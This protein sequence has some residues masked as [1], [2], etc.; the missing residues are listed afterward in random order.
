[1]VYL[2]ALYVKMRHEG[3]VENRAVYVAIGI[4]LEGRKEVLGL[5]T[6]GNEDAKF[7]LGVLTE[8]K[9]RG[10]KDILIVCVDGLKGFPQRLKR[11]FPRRGCSC[12]LCIWCGPASTT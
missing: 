12:A 1:V 6:S 2:D 8:L 9:N 10:V 3:R 5:W 7:W 11:C 4:D